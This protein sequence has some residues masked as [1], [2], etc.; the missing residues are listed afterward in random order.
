MQILC[1]CIIQILL[2]QK[3]KCDRHECFQRNADRFQKQLFGRLLHGTARIQDTR[4]RR[5][6][7]C[8]CSNLRNPSILVS[9]RLATIKMSSC[10]ICFPNWSFSSVIRPRSSVNYLK[11]I[12]ICLILHGLSRRFIPIIAYAPPSS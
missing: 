9:S 5:S 2:L 6:A 12:S 11:L 4:F 8:F 10:V 3:S 7:A 1:K